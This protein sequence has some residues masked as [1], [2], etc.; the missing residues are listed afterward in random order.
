MMKWI[1]HSS[2]VARLKCI[3]NHSIT[4]DD[5]LTFWGRLNWSWITCKGEPVWEGKVWSFTRCNNCVFTVSREESLYND[6]SETTCI[7]C[8]EVSVRVKQK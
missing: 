5:L 4:L 7:L 3:I 6:R 8:K 2:S 1:P